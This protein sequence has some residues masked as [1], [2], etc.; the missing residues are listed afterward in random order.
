MNPSFKDFFLKTFILTPSPHLFIFS[1]DGSL[2]AQTYKKRSTLSH[3]VI[4]SVAVTISD[5]LNHA[6]HHESLA[7]RTYRRNQAND[8]K[9]DISLEA[10]PSPI[11]IE[12]ASSLP[13]EEGCDFSLARRTYRRTSPPLQDVPDNLSLL[14]QVSSSATNTSNTNT[15]GGGERGGGEGEGDGSLAARTYKKRKLNVQSSNSREDGV[16]ESSIINMS[17]SIDSSS[18]FINAAE[19]SSSSLWLSS[20]TTGPSLE[21][22]TAEEIVADWT[23][24]PWTLSSLPTTSSSSS[25]SSSSARE[26]FDNTAVTSIVSSSSSS[27]PPPPPA[28]SSPSSATIVGASASDKFHKCNQCEKVFRSRSDLNSHVRIHSGDKP[29]ACNYPGCTKSFAHVS[30]LRVH[31]RGHLGD[32]PYV[33]PFPGC[34]RAF[35]HPSSRTD[36]YVNIHEGVRQYS[37]S[38]CNRTFTAIS[39]MKRHVKTCIVLSLGDQIAPFS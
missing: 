9:S 14:A 2:A 22:S 34:G 23:S 38:V 10:P 26:L 32:R 24:L 19:S 31:E 1:S 25:S 35:R 13:G 3:P 21:T 20:S 12:S 28:T 37:C 17:T 4:E 16:L 5:H 39:N 29:L 8:P 6:P 33:C 27:P 7:A 18:V 15:I 36:H 11:I 30:N